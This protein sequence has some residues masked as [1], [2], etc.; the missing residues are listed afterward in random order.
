VPPVPG[1]IVAVAVAV[2]V[3]VAVVVGVG[4]P[5]RYS[6]ANANAIRCSIRSPRHRP[7]RRFEEAASLQ[8]QF[9]ELISHPPQSSGRSA[10]LIADS[11]SK[12]AGNNSSARTT[13]RLPSSRCASVTKIRSILSARVR[14]QIADKCLF[15]RPLIS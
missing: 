6:D 10:A 3:A 7:V 13:K 9:V 4:V 1:V 12:N 2:G 14:E 5:D 8:R 15:V 11:S